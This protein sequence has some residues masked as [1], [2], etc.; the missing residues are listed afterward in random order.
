MSSNKIKQIKLERTY[1]IEQLLNNSFG[2]YLLDKCIE[3]LTEKDITNYQLWLK[4]RNA[5]KSLL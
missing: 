4:Q 2:K 1:N 5:I 3:T